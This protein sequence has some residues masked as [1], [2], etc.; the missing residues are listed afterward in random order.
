M[1]FPV[2]QQLYKDDVANFMFTS[3]DQTYVLH[4]VSHEMFGC[5][6]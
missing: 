2:N 5:R 4:A 6:V 1:I 3:L